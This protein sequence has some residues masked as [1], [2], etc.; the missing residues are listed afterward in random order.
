MS[1]QSDEQGTPERQS[2]LAVMDANEY[3]Q[4][5]RLQRV[6]DAQDNVEDIANQAYERYTAG[7]I[8]DD[9]KNIVLLRA[10]KQYIRE[11]YNLLLDHDDQLNDGEWNRYLDG[12]PV[13]DDGER[14][15]DPLGAI[16]MQ[17]GRPVYF[18]GLLDVLHAD[19]FY[20]DHWVEWTSRRH[21]PDEPVEQ[22]ATH[23]VSEDVTWNAYL[24]MRRFLSEEK[25]I[26]LRFEDM[27]DEL[28]VWGFEE[29]Q[30]DIDSTTEVVADE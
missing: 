20:D 2:D 11:G 14:L 29:V 13:N 16:D 8:T 25:D 18:W 1:A 6:L 15:G 27:G 23:T 21:G 12:P 24:L 17:G 7:E 22:S 28:P 9:A 5:R 4:K 19:T 30:E 26:E 10:V 3:K